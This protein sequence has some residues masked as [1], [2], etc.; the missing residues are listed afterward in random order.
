[1]N[2]DTYRGV[3]QYETVIEAGIHALNEI[4]GQYLTIAAAIKALIQ[5]IK[6]DSRTHELLCPTMTD[7]VKSVWK[8]FQALSVFTQYIHQRYVQLCRVHK[9]EPRHFSIPE[10]MTAVSYESTVPST[11]YLNSDGVNA[12]REARAYLNVCGNEIQAIISAY[13][14][15]F[16]ANI[17]EMQ[18]ADVDQFEELYEGL[19]K[20]A[21]RQ[22]IIIGQLGSAFEKKAQKIEDFLSSN[23]AGDGDTDPPSIGSKQ[24]RR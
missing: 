20:H 22:E 14:S 10:D 23:T 12:L 18:Q 4:D 19:Q 2:G 9:L 13:A 15:V 17:G 1:M 8:T 21:A 7:C 5:A 24:L 6:N 11:A 16:Q 3:T